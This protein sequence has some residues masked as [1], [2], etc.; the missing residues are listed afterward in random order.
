MK[1]PLASNALNLVRGPAWAYP[2]MQMNVYGLSRLA[3][4]LQARGVETIH[5]ALAP[6]HGGYHSGTLY[7]R[8]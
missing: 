3:L 6:P 8:R 1:L 2:H 4:I 5:V 7:F